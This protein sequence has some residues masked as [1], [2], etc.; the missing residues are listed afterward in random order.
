MQFIKIL[1]SIEHSEK[2]VIQILKMYA[3]KLNLMSEVDTIVFSYHLYTIFYWYR[4]LY[5]SIIPYVSCIL[6]INCAIIGLVYPLWSILY[7]ISSSKSLNFFGNLNQKI[8]WIKFVWS[9]Y[10]CYISLVKVVY[11][12]TLY[13]FVE[14]IIVLQI[15]I[16]LFH[17]YWINSFHAKTTEV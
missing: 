2:F 10:L 3:V 12:R 17:N 1:Y 8:L 15:L 4:A 11:I 14:T 6:M 7:Q 9:D 5:W 16:Q 13:L